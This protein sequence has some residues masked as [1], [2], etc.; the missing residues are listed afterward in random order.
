MKKL[1]ILLS[2]VCGLIIA[3]ISAFALQINWADIYVTPNGDSSIVGGYLGGDGNQVTSPNE[4]IDWSI[5]NCVPFSGTATS[6]LVFSTA[7]GDFM[8]PAN[9]QERMRITKG[10][11]IGI[12]TANPTEKLTVA[13]TIQSTSGGFKFPDGSLQTTAASGGGHYIGESYG[14]GIV[15]W[16]DSSGQHGL[17]AT[18]ADQS[19]GIQWYNGTYRYTGSLGDGLNAG[20]MNTAMI[21]AT[22]ISDNQTGNFA[23]KVCADYSVTVRV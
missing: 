19:T 16:V 9:W 11:N 5:G 4:W 18:T 12:G 15:F 17:I 20:A 21:V 6:D 10:G 23:A 2:L 13:G 14:G 3:P 7:V 8:T 1:M 22:Q